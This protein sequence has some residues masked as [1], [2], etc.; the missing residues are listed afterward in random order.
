[1][2][3]PDANVR[4]VITTDI[5]GAGVSKARRAGIPVLQVPL[6]P[7][8]AGALPGAAAKIDWP[9]LEVELLARSIDA[10]FLLGFMRIV[11]ASFIERW[12]GR[13]LNLH[14]S[15]LPSFPGLKSIERA[16][17]ADAPCGVTIHEVVAQVDA[18]PLLASRVSRAAESA[19][20]D[21]A[22]VETLV[23]IDEQRLVKEIVEKWRPNKQA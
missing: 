2:E 23:H 5:S 11:P 13:I 20:F 10:I 12:E 19:P 22:G 14:P 17:E 1:V 18:G 3:K 8:P 4:L 9:A 6:K 16:V 21:I 7:I 15:L